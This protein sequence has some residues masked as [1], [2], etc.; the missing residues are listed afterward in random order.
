MKVVAPDSAKLFCLSPAFPNSSGAGQRC[1][2]IESRGEARTRAHRSDSSGR[3]TPSSIPTPR[4]LELSVL[5]DDSFRS[6]YEPKQSRHEPRPDFFSALH[7]LRFSTPLHCCCTDT[8]ISFSSRECRHADEIFA[9][10]ARTEFSITT[11]RNLS[12]IACLRQ[13]GSFLVTS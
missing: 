6:S 8:S 10:S 12:D 1:S 2:G 13:L 5:G 4:R 11:S 3:R 7:P 9:F